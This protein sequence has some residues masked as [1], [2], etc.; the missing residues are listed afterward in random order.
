LKYHAISDAQEKLGDVVKIR[1]V[2]FGFQKAL[3][4]EHKNLTQE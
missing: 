3:Y 2:F 4:A 1:T